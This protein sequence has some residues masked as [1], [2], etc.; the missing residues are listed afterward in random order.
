MGGG[1]GAE[2]AETLNQAW[3]MFTGAVQRSM[4]RV[5]PE[6]PKKPRRVWNS[7]DA[8][9]IIEH[10][11]ALVEGGVIEEARGLGKMIKQAAREDNTQWKNTGTTSREALGPDQGSL[12]HNAPR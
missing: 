4:E 3:E 1:G 8:L 7:Q 9:E 11:K 6:R 5:A 2:D 10:R 12:P